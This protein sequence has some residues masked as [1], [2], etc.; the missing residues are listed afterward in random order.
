MT[1]ATAPIRREILIDRF[2]ALRPALM[3]HAAATLPAEL[4]RPLRAVTLHQF[5]AL[6]SLL[7]DGLLLPMIAQRRA[8]PTDDTLGLLTQARD[9]HGQP[10]SEMQLL[11]RL[12]ILL[13]A[14]HET[15]TTL[16]A[17]LLYLLATHPDYLARVHAAMDEALAKTDGAIPLAAVRAVHVLRHAVAE[18]GRL[19]SP[20]CNA[21][22]VTVRGVEFG[23]YEIP[24]NTRTLLGLA[25]CHML[26]HVFAH[27]ERFDPDR[28][29][30]P[31]EE[32]RRTPYGLVTYCISASTS[33]S[34]SFH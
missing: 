8:A 20:V 22:R 11:G 21:P 29:A 33:T 10:F 1:I 13:V 14:G 4:E 5:E 26:P 23:G 25:A 30:P 9:E 2:V 17:W 31:R 32:H 7:P 28:F 12:H 3:R 34:Q 19:R 24:E 16:S 6:A 15:T 27:P 18:A